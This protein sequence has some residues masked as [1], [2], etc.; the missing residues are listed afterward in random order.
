METDNLTSSPIWRWS[1]G[2][3]VLRVFFVLI[4]PLNLTSMSKGQDAKKEKKK[5]ATKSLKEKRAEK[6]AKKEAKKRGE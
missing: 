4:W 6:R 5:E 2:V 3:I 1:K